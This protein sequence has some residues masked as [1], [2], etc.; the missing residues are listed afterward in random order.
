M[1]TTNVTKKTDLPPY[2]DT[3]PDPLTGELGAHPIETGVGAALGGA[4]TGLVA[5]LAAGP[6]GAVAGAIIGGVAGGLGGKEVG[7]YIDP[8]VGDTYLEDN[9][10]K[11]SYAR[12]GETYETYQ[13]TYRYGAQAEAM[14]TGK[15]FEEVEHDVK[16]R[17]L[18]TEEAKSRG[19]DTVRDAVADG[20]VRASDLR[21]TR[22]S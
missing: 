19:W 12:T 21:K 5:G 22:K 16:T 15:P 6:I 1:K 20:Y 2:G 4:A 10:A 14:Y 11:R 3:N 18:T 7:E 8:T 17:Y 13:P 9:F